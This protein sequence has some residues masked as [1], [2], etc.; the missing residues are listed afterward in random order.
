LTRDGDKEKGRDG[1][2]GGTIEK[3]NRGGQLKGREK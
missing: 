2:K 1:E 3:E